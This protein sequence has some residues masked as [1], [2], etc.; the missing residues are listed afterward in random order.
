MP[1]LISGEIDMVPGTRDAALA[2]A[3]DLIAEALAEPG[4]RHYSWTAD[5]A[6]PDRIH[7]FEE[8][9]DAETL[10]AHFRAPSYFGMREHLSSFGIVKAET[11]KY[12]CDRV[13]PVYGPD[14]VA[15]AAFGA[16]R[17]R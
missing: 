4:C 12:R 9:D 13:E 10:A 15:R 2:G 6:N 5:P 11:R 1:I 14:G 3:A 16:E 8:W 17:A 7:V